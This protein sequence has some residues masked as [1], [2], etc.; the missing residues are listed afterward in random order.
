MNATTLPTLDQLSSMPLSEVRDFEKKRNRI[1]STKAVQ[2]K[3]ADC[4]D[5]YASRAI[6]IDWNGGSDSPQ[7]S[8]QIIRSCDAQWHEFIHRGC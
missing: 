2:Y 1:G 5:D 7:G 6:V 4:S 3:I 8:R